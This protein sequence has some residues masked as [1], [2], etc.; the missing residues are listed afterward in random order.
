MGFAPDFRDQYDS[1]NA[2]ERV[3]ALAQ[4]RLHASGYPALRHLT[5]HLDGRRLV[6]RGRVPN[7][8]HKQLAQAN[9]ADLSEEVEIVNETQVTGS[10]QS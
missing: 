9:L 2:L 1:E 10:P 5:C 6:I 7:Y 3:E 8:Y 4:R